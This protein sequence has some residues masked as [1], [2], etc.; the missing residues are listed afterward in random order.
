MHMRLKHEC[1]RP[2][3]S[4]EIECS[5]SMRCVPNLGPRLGA[6]WGAVSAA[7]SGLREAESG[8]GV[9][10]GDLDGRILGPE[11][12]YEHVYEDIHM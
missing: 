1:A 5:N 6:L 8:F 7:V 3:R 9:P 2:K 11:A 10:I 12:S 4:K